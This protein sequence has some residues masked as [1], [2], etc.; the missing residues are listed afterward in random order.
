V[1]LQFGSPLSE[2]SGLFVS[3]GDH[4]SPEK[5]RR[6]GRRNPPV[7]VTST[8]AHVIANLTSRDISCVWWGS[9][10]DSG[11]SFDGRAQ[12]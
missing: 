2:R 5:G 11:T 12:F 8:F 7:S 9:R 4:E 10:R 6:A 1:S 3:E